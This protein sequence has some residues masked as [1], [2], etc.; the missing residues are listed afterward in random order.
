[1]SVC[2]V[3]TIAVLLALGMLGYAPI[4]RA[5]VEV[6]IPAAFIA[7]AIGGLVVAFRARSVV[8]SG[9]LTAATMLIVAGVVAELAADPAVRLAQPQGIALGICA[10]SISVIGMG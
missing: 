3:V 7:T 1:G 2:A 5:A 8:A 4:G 10:V 9:S 6:G